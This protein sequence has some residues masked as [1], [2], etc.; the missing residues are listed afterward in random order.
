ME[1]LRDLRGNIASFSFSRGRCRE[2]QYIIEGQEGKG[3][4]SEESDWEEGRVEERPS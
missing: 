3:N 4:G 2:D 1:A